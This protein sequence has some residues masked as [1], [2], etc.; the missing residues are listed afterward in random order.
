MSLH[1]VFDGI[2]WWDFSKGRSSLTDKRD[3]EIINKLVTGGESYEFGQ[4]DSEIINTRQ[5]LC[6]WEVTIIF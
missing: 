1:G 6:A 2:F 4:V 3:I 5:S